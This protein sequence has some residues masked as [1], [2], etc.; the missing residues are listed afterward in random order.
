MNRRTH[1]E[2][3]FSNIMAVLFA[4]SIFFLNILYALSYHD[5]FKILPFRYPQKCL[6]VPLYR[7][8]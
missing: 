2:I 8:L 7:N 5:L 3:M 4:I 6:C 1:N